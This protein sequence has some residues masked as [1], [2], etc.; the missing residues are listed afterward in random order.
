MISMVLDLHLTTATLAGVVFI[1]LIS[2][3]KK[4]NTPLGYRFLSFLFLS[5]AFVFAEELVEGYGLY[6]RYPALAILFQPVIYVF[7]PLIYLSV[8]YLTTIDKKLTIRVILHFIP[9]LL[10][11]GL[12][13]IVYL[14]K[15]PGQSML[16]GE[17]E[18][19]KQAELLLLSLFFIQLLVYL[20]LSV[21]KL[22]QHRLTLPLFVSNLS[23]ND[24]HWLFKTI[25]GLGLL[26]L[27]S[28][29]E[30]VV[31]QMNQPFYF[32]FIYLAGFYYIGVQIANQKDVFA[33]SPQERNSVTDL[34]HAQQHLPEKVIGIQEATGESSDRE[35]GS[36]ES[37][38]VIPEHQLGMYKEKLLLLMQQEKPYL[39]SELTLPKLA[40]WL[41]MNTYQASYLINTCFAENFY[42]YIN[43]YRLEECKRMLSGK[44]Y[45]HLSILGIAFECGFNSKTTFNTAFKKYT[46]LS[47]KEFKSQRSGQ[48]E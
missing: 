43:R 5:L 33:F 48:P 24:Y 13:V 39:D 46:S 20:V 32:S 16:S 22:R 35:E 41:S 45:D 27:L 2:L 30:V 1:A 11:L 18:E 15:S 23:A 34:I 19:D 17:T 38:K 12:Y 28:L 25:I 9:Y 7:A 40:A 29:M 26:S 3:S 44:E 8:Y 14:S 36:V 42:S 47:P 21:R 10:V 4:G 31:E 37:R 6:N